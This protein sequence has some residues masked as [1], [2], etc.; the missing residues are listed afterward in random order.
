V[1]DKETKVVKLPIQGQF[2]NSVRLMLEDNIQMW[3]ERGWHYSDSVTID[4][5]FD[6]DTKTNGKFIFLIFCK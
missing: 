3:R 2:T 6:S 1:R 5:M 4:D